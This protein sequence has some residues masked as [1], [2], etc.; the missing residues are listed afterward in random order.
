M[1]SVAEQLGLINHEAESMVL[2]TMLQDENLA[3]ELVQQL[4]PEDFYDI[5]RQVLFAAISSLLRGVEPLTRDNVLAEARRVSRE[6][7]PKNPVVIPGE[8]LDTLTVN[9]GG[10]LRAAITVRRLAWLRNA[11]EYAR[12]LVEALQMNPDPDELYAEA[13]SRWQLLAPK[14]RNGVTLYGWDTLRFA[15]EVIRRHQEEAQLGIARRFDWPW[16]SWNDRIRPGIPGWVGVLAAPDGVGKSTYL[17]YIAEHWAQR[18]NRVVLVHL[19]DDHEYK[20]NRRLTRWARVPL[21]AIEDGTLGPAEEQ[22][23][24]EAEQLMAPWVDNL[25][26][27]HMPGAS[28]TEILAEVEKLIAEGQ[29]EALVLDYID[30]C[31]PDRRQLQLFGQ[32][33]YLR[34]GDNMN[35]L[36]NFAEKHGIPVFTATQGNKRMQDQGR[37]KTRQDI[38]GSGRKSQRA[39]LVIVLTRDIVGEGGLWDASGTKIADAGDYSPIATLRIDKQNRGR[40]GT[41][42]QVFRGEFFRIGDLPPGFDKDQLLSQEASHVR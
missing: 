32:Q 20:I 35:L 23:I 25:H 11:G 9:R 18:G 26:Y 21:S 1:Q 16:Q 10:A 6:M 40:T 37:I 7:M 13:Q 15:R 22:A 30:K 39:Q 24:R 27:T 41:F 31:E 5:R 8:F 4:S 33:H 38:E 36:K 17:D 28:I 19:E 3:V 29:C 14:R 12:W 42:H 2:G 34:E